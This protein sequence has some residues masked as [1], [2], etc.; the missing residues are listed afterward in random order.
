MKDFKIIVPKMDSDHE[1]LDA[2]FQGRDE[3]CEMAFVKPKS[4]GATTKR[5]WTPVKFEATPVA[6]G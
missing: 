4:S 3:R 5:T 2:E 6:G 1:E